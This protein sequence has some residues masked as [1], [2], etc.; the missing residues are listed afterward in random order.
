M[1]QKL[2]RHNCVFT[3]V[4]TDCTFYVFVWSNLRTLQSKLKFNVAADSL[5][6]RC[7]SCSERSP[8]YSITIL[9]LYTL[10][11]HGPPHKEKQELVNNTK[12]TPRFSPS[13]VN[14]IISTAPDWCTQNLQLLQ[15]DVRG[16]FFKWSHLRQELPPVF[17]Y[18]DNG[19]DDIVHCIVAHE[20]GEAESS[21][22]R[23]QGFTLR[24]LM[25]SPQMDAVQPT[26][27]GE[28]VCMCVH[29][30]WVGVHTGFSPG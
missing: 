22:S 28:R 19:L 11:S 4:C 21:D 29:S 5:L 18:H 3:Q 9:L 26:V 30:E 23:T 13:G 10:I 2:W 24:V 16:Y 6:T 15:F 14:N 1:K 20:I 8:S 7:R 17:G 27:W 25:V 12:L